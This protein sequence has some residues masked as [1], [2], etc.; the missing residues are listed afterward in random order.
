LRELAVVIV[1][2]WVS[3]K[4]GIAVE[5]VVWFRLVNCGGAGG[6]EADHGG[7]WRTVDVLRELHQREPAKNELIPLDS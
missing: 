3:G 5:L 6:A 2:V 7:S 4:N 1:A